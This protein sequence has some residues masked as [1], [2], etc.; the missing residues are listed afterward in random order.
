METEIQT[1]NSN[2]HNTEEEIC[3]DQIETAGNYFDIETGRPQS[4]DKVI[5]QSI[6]R[7]SEFTWFYID[8]K[9]YPLLILHKYLDSDDIKRKM[10]SSIL[11]A[12]GGLKFEGACAWLKSKI[13]LNAQQVYYGGLYCKY[14]FGLIMPVYYYLFQGILKLSVHPK[15]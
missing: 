1:E 7:L 11:M 14:M 8:K 15:I 4:L 6:E 3:V 5:V 2:V 12:G 10:Y 9:K 13:S